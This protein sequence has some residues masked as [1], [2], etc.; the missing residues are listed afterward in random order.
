MHNQHATPLVFIARVSWFL[1]VNKGYCTTAVLHMTNTKYELP[2]HGTN[3][4]NI[5]Y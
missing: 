2:L 3:I 1:V 4:Y 5:I